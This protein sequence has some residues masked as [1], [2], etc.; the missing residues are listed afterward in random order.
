[1]RK[2]RA[3][4]IAALVIVLLGALSLVLLGW[5]ER[6]P[7]YQGKPLSY[8]LSDFWPGRNPTPEKLEQDKLAVRRI[9]TNA[10]PILL[11]WISAKDSSIKEKMV[12]WIYEHPW[13]PFRIRS[14]LDKN[15]LAVTGF[16]ILGKPQAS[17]AIPALIEFVRRGVGDQFSGDNNAT[18]P[19]IALADLDR[20]A[21]T[22]AGIQFGT[23]GNVIGWIKPVTVTNR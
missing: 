1:M 16:S 11:R 15:M 20:E 8:W 10:I 12:T 19:M 3:A 23:N 17:S 13:M 18:F 22:N 7:V 5:G 2:I 14:S 4:V 6:E 9:G 21:A